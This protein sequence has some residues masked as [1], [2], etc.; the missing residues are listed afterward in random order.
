M[1][2]EEGSMGRRE[3]DELRRR[4]DILSYC[5]WDLENSQNFIHWSSRGKAKINGQKRGTVNK[6]I[7]YINFHINSVFGGKVAQ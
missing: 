3:T 4:E 5:V 6:I 1:G 7:F 2:H